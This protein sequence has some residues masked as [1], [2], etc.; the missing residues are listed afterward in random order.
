MST[1]GRY[2]PN[3]RFNRILLILDGLDEYGGRDISVGSKLDEI[4]LDDSTSNNYHRYQNTKILIT[5]RLENDILTKQ[6]L[7]KIKKNARLLPFDPSQINYFFEKYGV[8]VAAVLLPSYCQIHL[9][10][11]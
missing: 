8:V 4:I 5:S 6:H 7:D 11:Y 10:N 3:N 1:S 2:I 9:I